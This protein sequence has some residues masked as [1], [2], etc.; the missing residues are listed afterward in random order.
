MLWQTI[1]PFAWK[2]VGA[3]VQNNLKLNNLLLPVV[4]YN[5]TSSEVHQPIHI[6]EGA[7]RILAGQSSS[8]KLGGREVTTSALVS[9]RSWIRIPSE[10]PVKYFHRHSEST[11]YYNWWLADNPLITSTQ[12]WVLLF[13]STMTLKPHYLQHRSRIIISYPKY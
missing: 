2:G 6:A 7:D 13:D 4:H 9:R 12:F 10:S 3:P 1:G 8:G 11:I 5:F